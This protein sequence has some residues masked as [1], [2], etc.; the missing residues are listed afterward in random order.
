MPTGLSADYYS[1]YSL[2]IFP[3][4]SRSTCIHSHG[5]TT[6]EYWMTAKK[7]IAEPTRVH[8]LDLEH[9][10]LTEDEG[11]AVTMLQELHPGLE[12]SWY[13]VPIVAQTLTPAVMKSVEVN[14][15][16]LPALLAS[17]NTTTPD[18]TPS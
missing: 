9:P 5:H 16:E 8:T 17:L 11:D 2:L 6:P 15:S 13:Y 18:S 14:M 7:I 12:P 1:N 10:Y 4:Y 3:Q